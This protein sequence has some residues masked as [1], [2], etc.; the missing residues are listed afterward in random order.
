MSSKLSRVEEVALFRRW[1][2]GDQR[3][4]AA[5]VRDNTPAVEWVVRRV[6]RHG[7]ADELIA[8]GMHG[9]A[10]A[11]AKFDPE[12]GVRFATYARPWIGMMIYRAV[13]K[14]RTPCLISG[15]ARRPDKYFR[16]L[17]GL[18]DVDAQR[19]TIEA[20]A[21]ALGVSVE[22]VEDARAQLRSSWA[23]MHDCGLDCFPDW[24]DNPEAA[25]T[26]A[27]AQSKA[28][29]K[30]AVALAPLDARELLI[31]RARIM[32][33]EPDTFQVLGTALGVTRERARQIETIALRKMRE[34]LEE[35]GPNDT[36]NHA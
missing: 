5:L 9:L 14:L 19:S 3:A 35:S 29:S 7:P 17:R 20:L 18:H 23:N 4:A 33:D 31:V 10:I 28:H 6:Q 1:R 22:A 34:A 11:M 27:Q 24:G 15:F 8:E 2:A 30:A 16:L 25:L 13:T 26:I 12:R 32:S 21:G 36:H